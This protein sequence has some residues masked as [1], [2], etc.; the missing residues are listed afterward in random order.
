[1]RHLLTHTSG[2]LDRWSAWDDL[3][4]DG[5]SA[6]A[7]GDF[8]QGYLEPGGDDYR[9][10]NFGGWAPGKVYRYSNVGAT[11]AAYLVEVAGGIGFDAWCEDRVFTPLGMTRA[12]WHLADVPKADVA[13][14]YRWSGENDRYVAYG[15]YGY[16]DYPDGALR[17]TAR[18][19]GHHMG[20]MM[21][22]GAWNGARVLRRETVREMLHSQIPGIASGQGLI[23][24]RFHLHGRSLWGHNGGDQ[25][26]ATAAFFEPRSDVGVVVLANGNWR[27]DGHRWPLQQ[28]MERLF[29]DAGA[30][31]ELGAAA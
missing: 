27:M 11:L 6:I 16:P 19:L 25:G 26:V 31:S 5:D 4:A 10:A 23:W 24:Y 8:L 15:Q 3:Y 21:N 14:P 2:I 7:L 9:V 1:M 17:T 20:M 28:I 30:L 29:N 22:G 13:M 18:Q 12:G